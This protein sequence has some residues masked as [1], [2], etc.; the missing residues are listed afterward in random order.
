MNVL[1]GPDG[2]E[3]PPSRM[4]L[5]VGLLAAIVVLAAV[6]WWRARPTPVEPPPTAPLESPREDAARAAEP[7]DPPPPAATDR[8][9]A[10][11]PAEASE[12]AR[13]R[14]APPGPLLRVDSDVPGAFV[15]VD[16]RY[17]GETPL[18]TRDVTPG[19]HHINVS[20]EGYDGVAQTVDIAAN[21]PTELKVELKSIRLDESVAVIHKHRFG[22]CTGRLLATIEGLRYETDRKEDAFV[23]PFSELQAFEI[24]YPGKNLR[25]RALGGRT[26]NFTTAAENA[27][28]LFV[29][30]RSVEAA[31]TKL[32]G[33]GAP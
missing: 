1:G 33:T 9:P 26:W 27:D 30:H 10:R 17:V 25:V 7:A 21:E 19:P 23:L 2:F 6:A 12:R 11:P 31:R 14:T 28:P 8:T 4:P 20:A 16:R 22:S 13:P 29:F 15:F 24:D 32:I 5:V 3:P 18:E